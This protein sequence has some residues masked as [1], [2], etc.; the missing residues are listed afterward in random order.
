M[1]FTRFPVNMTR[2]SSR[3]MLSEPYRLH[4][5]IAGSFPP[6]AQDEEGRVLWRVDKGPGG[7]VL[8]YIVSPT[9]PSL[10]GLNEQIGWPDLPPQ[11]QTKDYDPFLDRIERGQLYGFRLTAN[12]VLSTKLGEG[13][14]SKRVGHL[15]VLQQT[16]WLAGSEA[17]VQAG[18]DVPDLFTRQKTSRAERNGF[19]IARDADD[20]L[21]V[22][23]TE[24]R[25]RVVRKQGGGK[26]ITLA[27][28]QYD[29]VLEVLDPDLLRKALINGIGHGKGFGCGLLTL[30]P[31]DTP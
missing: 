25:K 30:V 29:G 1:F 2:R 7:S 20:V 11:W 18:A 16:A 8:L 12:P 6:G 10:V 14:R 22:M 27:M 15:T 19:A 9:Q 4:A 17:F 26:D 13:Q 5:A 3:A 23:L 24:S 21:Q 28:A 31:V